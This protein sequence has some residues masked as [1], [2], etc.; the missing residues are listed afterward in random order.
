VYKH[1]TALIGIVDDD[2]SVLRAL[3]RLLGGAGFAVK[4][5][6]SAEKFL[7]LEHPESIKC[8][9]LDIQM[10]GLSGFELQERLAETDVSIPIIFITAHDDVLTRERARKGGVAYLP[11]PFDAHSLLKAIAAALDGK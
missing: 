3:S 6:S 11:K 10:P 5:F 8:L 1:V 2:A 7:A 9:V 4:A